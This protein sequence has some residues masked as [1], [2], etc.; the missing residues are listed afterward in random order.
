MRHDACQL[1]YVDLLANTLDDPHIGVYTP[2]YVLRKPLRNGKH[3]GIENMYRAIRN[4]IGARGL[5]ALVSCAAAI[6]APQSSASEA[7]ISDNV[8]RLGVLMPRQC[9]RSLR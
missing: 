5:A 4:F 8:V 2:T 9:P 6:G 3:E 7:A 1:Y